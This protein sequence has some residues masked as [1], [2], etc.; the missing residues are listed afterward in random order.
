MNLTELLNRGGGKLTKGRCNRCDII[1]V[2][3]KR[4]ARVKDTRCHNCG[5]ALAP[6]LHFARKPAIYF[7]AAYVKETRAILALDY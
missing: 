3:P 2:W 7:L 5:S 4:R 6:T 1:L